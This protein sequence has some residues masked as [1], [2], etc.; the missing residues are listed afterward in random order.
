[1]SKN[2]VYSSEEILKYYQSHRNRWEDFYPSEKWVFERIATGDGQ[3]GEVLD[4]GCAGGGL[5]KALLERFTLSSYTGIDIHRGIIEWAKENQKLN[6]PVQFF[7]E[8]INVIDLKRSYDLVASLGC[9]DWNIETSRIIQSCWD[10]VKPGGYFV[11]S[12]RLTDGEGIN[13]IGKSYQYI[14]F[15]GADNEPEVAN[16]VVTN[17]NEAI[18]MLGALDPAPELIGAYGY[19]GKP[20]GTAATP[21][22]RILFSVFFVRKE[23]K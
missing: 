3:L 12:L 7:A 9:A 4:V 18:A 1:M 6:V 14:N 17:Y 21:F 20:S 15:S 23:L 13:D 2:I 16:Y 19:W 11:G 22:S 8:D 10:K 5:G